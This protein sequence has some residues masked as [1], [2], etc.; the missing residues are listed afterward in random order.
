QR[1]FDP[2]FST[3]FTGRGLGLAAVLGIV[4]SHGGAVVV[5]SAPGSGTRVR[6]YVSREEVAAENDESRVPTR[7]RPL[8][9]RA[10]GVV[11][12]VDDEPLVREVALL[13]L[14]GAG[15]DVLCACDGDE[16]L[17]LVRANGAGLVAVVLDVT[18]PKIDGVEFF[19]ALR[20]AHP[21]LP[22]LWSSGHSE[23]DLAR[24]ACAPYSD[25]LAKPYLPDELL[26]K[27]EA[28][29]TA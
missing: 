9:P 1:M 3:K 14:K 11:L 17:Q 25:F 22:V 20:A 7:G 18:M 8:A 10:R 27:L 26:A 6:V 23:H 24:L 28:L 19:A 2:F 5:D 13:T 29:V 16:G 15:F 21:L 4:H 12:V